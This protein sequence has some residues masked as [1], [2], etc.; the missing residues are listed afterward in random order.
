MKQTGSKYYYA[1]RVY[2]STRELLHWKISPETKA[3]KDFLVPSKV[4][5]QWLL[6]LHWHEDNVNHLSLCLLKHG[7]HPTSIRYMSVVPSKSP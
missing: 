4:D 7:K 6:I 3:I 1:T 5:G 2:I